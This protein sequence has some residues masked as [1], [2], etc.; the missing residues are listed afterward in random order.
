MQYYYDPEANAIYIRLSDEPY[1]HGRDLDP[2]RRI[3]YAEDGTPIGIELTCVQ[4]GVSVEALP[5]AHEIIEILR[6]LN[7][8]IFA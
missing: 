2:E 7:I 1:S 8:P 4:S 6:S 3:D 5:A